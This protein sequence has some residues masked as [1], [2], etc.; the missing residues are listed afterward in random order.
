MNDRERIEKA[1]EIANSYGF[2][3]G[4]HHKQ[5]VLDQMV[6][7]LLGEAEYTEWAKGS[8]EYPE[9]EVGIAP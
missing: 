2:I 9:W 4:E 3:D 7:V 5:W 8:E 1:M 6:R